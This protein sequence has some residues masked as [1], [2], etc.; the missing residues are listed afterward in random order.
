VVLTT[1]ALC[2]WRHSSSQD[3]AI[4]R[5]PGESEPPEACF[6]HQWQGQSGWKEEA[7][8]R[9]SRGTNSAGESMM[10]GVKDYIGLRGVG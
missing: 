5:G 10:E 1:H 3:G 9:G 4:R 2:L 8:V 6:S 7:R